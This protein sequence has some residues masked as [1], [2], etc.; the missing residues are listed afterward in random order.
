MDRTIKKGGNR[1]TAKALAVVA[2]LCLAAA[3]FHYSGLLSLFT[4]EKR[5]A[6]FLAELG[7]WGFAGFVLLQSS[8]VVLAPIPGE[9]TGLLGGYLYGPWLGTLLSTIGLTAGSLAAFFI[10]RKMG[11][12]LVEKFIDPETVAKFDTVLKNEGNFIAFLLFLLPGFPKDYLCYILGLGTIGYGLFFV[13]STVGR[14]A[15]T[16]LLNFGGAYL[17]EGRY[18]DFALIA[19]AAL[20]VA[21][22]SLIFRKKIEEKL[23]RRLKD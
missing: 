19:T 1:K 2:F 4:D 5:M 10:S 12:P 21:V 18:R 9:A 23:F 15:G 22:F 3:L 6:D 16:V 13:I 8:Q 14:F 20:L 7:P 11:R 17:R